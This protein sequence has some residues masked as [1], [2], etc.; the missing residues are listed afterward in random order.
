LGGRYAEVEILCKS[1]VLAEPSYW[2]SYSLCAAALQR[3]GRLREALHHLDRGLAYEPAESK[4]LAM[5]AE[6]VAALRR[7]V[8][9]AEGVK[10]LDCER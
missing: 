1:L 2:W 3:L 9:A 7:R 6:V 8:D 4:L 10:R 5:R